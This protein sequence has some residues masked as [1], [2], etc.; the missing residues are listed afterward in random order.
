M[1]QVLQQG[2]TL[3]NPDYTLNMFSLIGDTIHSW[4]IGIFFAKIVSPGNFLSFL[5]VAQ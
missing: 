2:Y 3:L 4:L 5:Q 1:V